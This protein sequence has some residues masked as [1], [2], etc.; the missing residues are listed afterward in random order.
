MSAADIVAVLVVALTGLIMFRVGLVGLALSLVGWVGAAILTFYGFPVFLPHV[1]E[2]TG[3][4]FAAVATTIAGLYIVSLIALAYVRRAVVGRI[5]R[6]AI[7]PLDRS[8]GLAAG[9]MLGVVILSGAY[10]GGRYLGVSY[11]QPFYREAR[12]MP[13]I[14]QGARIL[15]SLAPP[16]VTVDEVRIPRT[17]PQER[18][19]TLLEPKTPST[20]P[21]DAP[22]YDSEQRRA[23]DQL[24]D[25][26]NR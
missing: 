1:A 11:D 12:A 26:H 10:L 9:I 8:L 5:Q 3:K 2:L 15:V 14:R 7:G 20:D 22:G 6:S 24:F 18:F 4:G 23:M 19:R 21:G 25:A 16:S 13:L 17:D